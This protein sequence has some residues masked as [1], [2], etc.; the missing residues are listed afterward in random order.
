MTDLS[1]VREAKG[2]KFCHL[3]I[4]SIVNKIDQFR[5]HFEKS[6]FDIITLSETWLSS[7]IGNNILQLK[8]YQLYRA[9]RSFNMEND[10]RVKRGG[11]LLT[12][13]HRDINFTPIVNQSKNV[14]TPDCELQRI[15]LSS[16]VQKNIVVYNIY[17]PPAGKIESFIEA[18]SLVIE[19]ESDLP[20][21]EYLYLGDFNINYSAKK[22]TDTRK[23]ISWQNKLGLSQ[24]IKSHTRRSKKSNSMIDL[25]MTNVEHVLGWNNKSKYQ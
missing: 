9:D 13:V 24:L 14:S 23:L 20:R 1:S 10:R 4:R 16:K 11:G 22:S 25:I 6:G 7:D 17:R 21:K 19:G 3:N 18:L 12:Y 2:L 8:D 5:M 15:E